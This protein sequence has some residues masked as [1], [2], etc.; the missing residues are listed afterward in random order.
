MGVV[1]RVGA[2][3]VSIKNRLGSG[4][5]MSLHCQSKDN[6]LGNQTV[7][8]GSD[9]GWDFSPNAWGTTLFYCDLGWEGVPEFH[10]DAYVSSRDA[11][12]CPSDCFWLISLEGV[13]GLN[14]QTGLWEFMYFWP[15]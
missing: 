1:V 8:D 3:H 7:A 2:E 5:T 14:G 10:F 15:S 13:Y 12:R 11:V 6:D 9:Y 4:K